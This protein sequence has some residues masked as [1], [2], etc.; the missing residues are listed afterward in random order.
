MVINAC[1]SAAGAHSASN[2]ARL[3]IE[4]GV[5]NAVGMSYNVLS[6]TADLFMSSFY[7]K[8]LGHGASA[9]DAAS[10]ARS[11][12]CNSPLRSTN[13]GTQLRLED[14]IIP[15]IHC[16]ESA[17]SEL[18][19]SDLDGS[20]QPPPILAKN[21]SDHVLQGR[22][23]DILRLENWLAPPMPLKIL[24][25]G[26][27]G[28]GKTALLKHLAT[29]W[30]ATGFCSRVIYLTLDDPRLSPLTFSK[31]M[32]ELCLSAGLP[33]DLCKKSSIIQELN[34]NPT[35]LILDN[36]ESI[37]WS[38]EEDNGV[39][40][41]QIRRFLTK[42]R[43][44]PAISASRSE[45]SW[46][47]GIKQATFVL[48]PIQHSNAV[49]IGLQQLH[50]SGHANRVEKEMK[51][52]SQDFGQLISM[53]CGNPLAIKIII[54]DLTRYFLIKPLASLR[55]YLDALL[56]YKPIHIE[57]DLVYNEE[58]YRSIRQLIRI[59]EPQDPM[60]DSHVQDQGDLTSST[61]DLP[62]LARSP[63]LKTEIAEQA[64]SSKLRQNSPLSNSLDG[65]LDYWSSERAF[66]SPE[67]GFRF[68]LS[69]SIMAFWGRLLANHNSYLEMFFCLDR[70]REV[71]CNDD[72]NT[73][74]EIIWQL[75]D[76]S[77]PFPDS[78]Q[79]WISEQPE[80][81][82]FRVCAQECQKN[83]LPQMKC[84]SQLDLAAFVTTDESDPLYLEVNPILTL[85][86]RS[87]L[88]N[89][90]VCQP[91]FTVILDLAL[92][93][94]YINSF[95][96]MF[97]QA[98]QNLTSHSYKEQV[99][100]FAD[101]NFTNY[102]TMASAYRRTDFLL[103]PDRYLSYVQLFS[104]V[105]SNVR[106]TSLVLHLYNRFLE[107]ALEK[108]QAIK[109][110]LFRPGTTDYDETTQEGE[111]AKDWKICHFL[112]TSLIGTMPQAS[113]SCS[114][115]C[116]PD[117]IYVQ[118]WHHLSSHPLSPLYKGIPPTSRNIIG[119]RIKEVT[120]SFKMKTKQDQRL[121]Q[122]AES[123]R[124]ERIAS[125]YELSGINMPIPPLDASA[126]IYAFNKEYALQETVI[127]DRIG[128]RLIEITQKDLSPSVV[129]STS[130]V[131]QVIRELHNLLQDETEGP[132]RPHMRRRIHIE[133][134]LHNLMIGNYIRAFEHKRLK[135][136]MEQT[137]DPVTLKMITRDEEKYD[138]YW[139]SQAGEPETFNMM[140]KAAEEEIEAEQVD[141]K[142]VQQNRPND[143][144]DILTHMFRIARAHLRIFRYPVAIPIFRSIIDRRRKLFGIDDEGVVEP[145]YELA[146][147]LA[148]NG[149][150]EEAIPILRMLLADATKR[151]DI[152]TSK[153][154]FW[155]NLRIGLGESLTYKAWANRAHREE[156]W[157]RDLLA[158]AQ[159]LLEAS[160]EAHRHIYGPH[161]PWVTRILYTLALVSREQHNFARQ[162]KLSWEIINIRR[163]VTNDKSDYTLM[164]GEQSLA[165]AWFWLKR[166]DES[167]E[168]LKD[169]LHR[170][171]ERHSTSH[172]RTREAISKLGYLYESVDKL[173]QAQH[174][175]MEHFDALIQAGFLRRSEDGFTF[176]VKS[177]GFLGREGDL[178]KE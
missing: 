135:K 102:L 164:S 83:L 154:E 109:Y 115:I 147:A 21:S 143:E 122:E 45:V 140:V 121:S 138:D 81:C 85:V 69:I 131:E 165:Q 30:P 66:S 175:A 105:F 40:R 37:Q 106:R 5:R 178:S 126:N 22:E 94:L 54:T 144:L 49:S 171:I 15:I 17:T 82:R 97:M 130:R 87:F 120:V 92:A 168:L 73:F 12:L 129:K 142:E 173:E 51:F 6:H 48:K 172:I 161:D 112:E 113:Y 31:F 166:V 2:V 34:S 162:E 86:T 132:N 43:Q 9:V 16:S 88:A 75:S 36:L 101:Y 155:I 27:P 156:S 176:G 89:K 145:I 160:L 29:W 114:L 124:Q 71:F 50:T 3:L 80:S 96:V 70:A 91:R 61:N 7:E 152:E 99:S 127:M 13:Y 151:S 123:L 52:N 59:F 150:H 74:C 125:Y 57:H 100:H 76:K 46:L 67:S 10:Q 148:R 47:E 11:A 103:C 134:Y 35:L 25:K 14:Y 44:C 19:E 90:H 41:T 141:L 163:A 133:L 72:F 26:S 157:H 110:S 159:D 146:N 117:D 77:S 118:A 174:L 111:H 153:N 169:V 149:Q 23:D 107:I 60:V 32:T 95:C 28:I 79:H 65:K 98:G 33:L 78:L 170:H 108:I 56:D 128:I 8:L 55:D 53:M 42:L 84:L 177:I 93:R 136:D 1:R 18:L 38:T 137:M 4:A 63:G 116:Y 39:Q 139:E 68:R 64:P 104:G 167:E 158:E 62:L 24:L 20:L 119:I 58:A